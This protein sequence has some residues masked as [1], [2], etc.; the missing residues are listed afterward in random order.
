MKKDDLNI[1]ETARSL[2]YSGSDDS[3]YGLRDWLRESHNIHV[4][5]G[6]IWD[7]K[8]NLVES[9]FFTITAPIYQYHIQSQCSGNG[10]NHASMLLQGVIQGMKILHNYENQKH[11]KVNDD[12]LIVAYLKGYGEKGKARKQETYRTS[13]EEYAYLLGKQGDYIEEGLTDDDIVHLVRNPLPREEQLK[14]K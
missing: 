4:E 13:I 9:Y 1:L 14:L 7:E 10:D 11:L 6:S 5:V 3:L 2:G 8:T 12:E